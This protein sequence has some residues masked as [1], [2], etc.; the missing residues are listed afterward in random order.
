VL[1]RDSDRRDD[2]SE[3]TSAIALASESDA[4]VEL[5]LRVAWRH[6]IRPQPEPLSDRLR[7]FAAGWTEHPD[8]QYRPD[9]WALREEILDLVYQDL[10]RRLADGGL[11]A[12]SDAI[13]RAWPYLVTRPRDLCDLVTCY[14]AAAALRSVPA[15]QRSARL[16]ALLRHAEAS[17][18]PAGAIACLQQAC[19]EWGALGPAE[20]LRLICALPSTVPVAQGALDVAGPEI[21]RRADRPT[22]L[23]LDALG[24]LHRRGLVPVE[25]PYGELLAADRVVLGFVQATRTAKFR[26]DLHWGRQWVSKLER[27]DAAVTHARLPAILQACLE[28]P[29]PGLGSAVLRVLPGRLPDELVRRWSRELAGGQRVRAA[30]EG[31]CWHEDDPSREI[32]SAIADTFAGLASRLAQG[33]CDRLYEQVLDAIGPD[34]AAA[35]GALLGYKETRVR[36]GRRKDGA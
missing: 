11:R 21:R 20:A 18:D 32:R 34:R 26:D 13:E 5:L 30:V 9:N 1:S 2:E 4:H 19:V 27:A 23:V 31:F 28:F 29:Q 14:V 36:R 35:W 24:V 33:D 17:R 3:L 22:V 8:A 6:G 16:S 10:Q 15:D 25:P 7:L 12:V